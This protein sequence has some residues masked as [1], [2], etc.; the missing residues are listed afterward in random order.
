MASPASPRRSPPSIARPNWASISI[1]TSD[2]YA[3]GK[4]E[5]LVGRAIKGRRDKIALATK[6]GQIRRPDG[7]G[8]VN[9]RPDYVRSRLR[10]EPR[11][12]DVDC[13]DLYYIHRIDRDRAD[14]GHGG[15][16]GRLEGLGKIR[17]L[18]ISEAA[19]ATFRRAHKTH[20]IAALQTEYSLWTRD[21]EECCSIPAPS[22]A[23]CM[24][25]MR[26]WGAA[27]SPARST[28]DAAL[29]AQGPA[30]RA[31]ALLSGN[32]ARNVRLPRFAA[33]ARRPRALHPGAARARLAPEPA[34]VHGAAARHEA[35][36][37][38]RGERGCRGD[39]AFGRD[40]R[41]A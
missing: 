14:R 2:A 22:S 29:G 3:N 23:F 32:M 31:S 21:A 24:S 19:P 16:D 35:A 28:G 1:D 30:A 8:E 36:A 15:R 41:R 7:A 12:L 5:E 34:P 18:G 13:I 37:L 20:P 9:G 33:P 4:N 10:G 11:R 38:A 25:P 26:R 39:R 6:F 27:S 17:H 40:A